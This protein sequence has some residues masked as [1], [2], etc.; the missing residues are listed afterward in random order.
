MGSLNVVIKTTEMFMN[1]ILYGNME[2][3][4]YTKKY[5]KI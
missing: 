5:L 3:G 4:H 2:E 1:F